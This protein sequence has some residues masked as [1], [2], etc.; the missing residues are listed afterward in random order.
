MHAPPRPAETPGEMAAL[1]RP[2]P[3]N[4]QECTAPP[5]PE[6]ALGFNCYPAPP[7]NFFICRTPKQK[8]ATP[9]ILGN[10]DD[11]GLI[12]TDRQATKISTRSNP[13]AH[14][15]VFCLCH[16]LRQ[17]FFVKFLKFKLRYPYLIPF[18]STAFS[19]LFESLGSSSDLF[20][21]LPLAP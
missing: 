19:P 6:N 8:K 20:S 7:R 21:S 1:G 14:P 12:K 9:C 5:R 4:F 13:I 17:E 15:I 2:G 11:L 16:C 18:L 3:E 10:Y